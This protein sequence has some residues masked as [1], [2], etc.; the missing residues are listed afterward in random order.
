MDRAFPKVK[1]EDSISFGKFKG[2]T[3]KEI[4][5]IDPQYVEWVIRNNRNLILTLSLSM[6]HYVMPE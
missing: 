6:R 4:K 2:K 3:Y 1:V 5:D